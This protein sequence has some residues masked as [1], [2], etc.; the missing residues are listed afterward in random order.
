MRLVLSVVVLAAVAAA[1]VVWVARLSSEAAEAEAFAASL[2]APILAEPGGVMVTT[3]LPIL[4]VQRAPE[5]LVRPV[6]DAR[7]ASELLP[8]AASW[9]QPFCLDVHIDGRQVL[10][11]GEEA[12]TPASVEKLLSQWHSSDGLG[13][14]LGI[15]TW[16]GFV[17]SF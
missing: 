12:Q 3:E 11:V 1:P 7:L 13:D 10:S 5:A 17:P 9:P 6:I 4:R 8:V 16:Q 14:R 15:L 2:R